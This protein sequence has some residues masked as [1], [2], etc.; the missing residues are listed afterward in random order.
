VVVVIVAVVEAVVIFAFVSVGVVTVD[1]EV[2]S[3]IV[4]PA[5]RIIVVSVGIVAVKV[6]ELQVVVQKA[7]VV[8]IMAAVEV[9]SVKNSAGDYVAK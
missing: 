9:E 4:V 2:E 7:A 5:R 6:F 8:E 1:E 3:A